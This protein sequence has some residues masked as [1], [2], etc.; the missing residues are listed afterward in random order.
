[1]RSTVAAM[2]AA[3]LAGMLATMPAAAQS[4]IKILVNGLPIT[5][6]DI[7]QRTRLNELSK[8]PGGTAKAQDELINEAVQ[9]SEVTRLGGSVGDQQ[10]DN[11]YASVAGNMKVSPTQLTSMLGQAGVGSQTLKNRLKAQLAWQMLMRAK[12]QQEAK[13]NAKDVT[14]AL[15]SS[16]AK[17][18]A[19]IKEYILQPVVFIVPKGSSAELTAQR[20]REAEAF[21]SRF[22]NCGALLE[23]AKGLRNVVVKPTMRRDSTQLTGATG[24][25]LKNLPAGKASAPFPDPDGISIVG[26]CSVRTIESTEAAREKIENKFA[27]ANSD[28]VGKEY[29]KELRS[30]A[31]IKYR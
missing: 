11:A 3:L 28:N 1:M 22:T 21:R 13:K 10:I 15:Q 19:Q 8:T 24:D 18:A 17:E 23:Q 26:V 7:A 6:Y 29:L 20:R 27:L 14:A 25:L 12:L 16:E 31:V 9:I 2:G 30:K 4:S 5:N